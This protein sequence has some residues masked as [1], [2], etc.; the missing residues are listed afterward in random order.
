MSVDW[1]VVSALC[2][3]TDDGW[4]G[5]A[6]NIVVSLNR[7]HRDIESACTILGA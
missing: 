2:S 1:W 6:G 4:V 3:T 7:R 5:L